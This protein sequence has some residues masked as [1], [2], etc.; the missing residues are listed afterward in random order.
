MKVKLFDKSLYVNP[1][2]MF[3]TWRNE[4][5]VVYDEDKNTYA[6]TRYADVE[7]AFR[8]QEV[9]TSSRGARANQIPQPFMI[10]ADDPSHRVQRKIVERSFTPGQMAYYSNQI[11]E[12]A[13]DLVGQSCKEKNFDFVK[14]VTHQIPVISIGRIL[15]IPEKDYPHLQKW[16]QAMVEGADGWENVT[17][18]VIAAVVEWYDYFEEM[19]KHKKKHPDGGVISQLVSAHYDHGEIPLAQVGGNALALLV[20]GNETAR[21]LLSGSVYELLKNRDQFDLL[22]SNNKLMDLAIEECSRF[23]SP[24]VSSIRHATCDVSISGVKIEKDSQVM[25][26]LPSANRDELVFEKP[27]IFDINKKYVKNIGFGFGAHY[28][29]GASLAKVQLR[30]ILQSIINICPNISIA[31]G[32]EPEIKASTFLRGIK[33]L[34]VNV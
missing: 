20:G 21:Y 13:S 27:E 16:G 3:K 26:L 30:V 10:D 31:D 2:E 29:L 34:E 33:S 12:I 1:Y 9:F 15:G 19:A 17:D 8:N 14:N 32:F 18:E 7:L 25:L 22:I 11:E 23:V 5:P 4:S 28:C 24:V 6:L